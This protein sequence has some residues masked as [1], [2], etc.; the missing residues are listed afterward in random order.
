MLLLFSFTAALDVKA[1]DS[2]T[3]KRNEWGNSREVLRLTITIPPQGIASLR[4]Q[5]RENVRAIV[6][7]GPREYRNVAIHVKGSIGS[8]RSIDEKPSLTLSFSKSD[9]NQMFYGNSKVHLNNSVE[10]ASYLNERLGSLIFSKAGVATPAVRHAMIELNGRHLGLY[11]VKEGFTREFLARHF[12]DSGGALY[13][14]DSSHETTEDL[15]TSP[16]EAPDEALKKL[17][18]AA[19]ISDPAGRWQALQ[20]IVDLDEFIQFMAIEVM[21]CHRDG[22]S[23]A[24]NNY[25]LYHDPSANRFVFLP[26]GMD[27]LFGRTDFPWRP[28]MGGMVARA[29]MSVPEGDRRYRER[30]GFLVTNVFDVA[31]LT[32]EIERTSAALPGALPKGEAKSFKDAVSDLGRRVAQ[33][34]AFLLRELNRPAPKPLGFRDQIAA[35][36]NWVATDVPE[37]GFLEVAKG[38]DQN[39]SL[40]I[41][42]GPVTAASWRTKVLLEPGNYRFEGRV[43]TGGVLPLPYGRSKGARLRVNGHPAKPEGIIG[44]SSWKDLT[45]EFAITADLQEIELVCELRA[46]KGDAWFDRDS[47]RLV[48]VR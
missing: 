20:R 43:R 18:D 44:T 24:R 19:R 26:H 25:R 47:L 11:V 21:I 1:A 10:D 35:V 38:P 48:R 32:A 41:H 46:T 2:S 33:R 22:Y 8:F 28:S 42:A 7:D 29:V 6:T 45:A 39:A 23:V 17:S 9:S 15:E 16:G 37:K 27:Q 14:T 31:E 3:N 12:K 40:H 34:K 13:D 5:S 36:T 30:F 4:T